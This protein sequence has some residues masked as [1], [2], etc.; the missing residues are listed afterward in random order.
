[1]PIG[2]TSELPLRSCQKESLCETINFKMISAHRFIFCANQTHLCEMKGFTGGVVLNH[3]HKLTWKWLFGFSKIDSFSI[4]GKSHQFV[5]FFKS[6]LVM[7]YRLHHFSHLYSNTDQS[8]WTV[9]I[10]NF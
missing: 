10:Q 8:E 6:F 9:S 7:R 1:M 2:L 5:K 3:R 4:M